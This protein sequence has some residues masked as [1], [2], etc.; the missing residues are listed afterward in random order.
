MNLLF[1]DG[2]VKAMKPTQTVSGKLAW[3][4]NMP[5]ADPA[6]CPNY[7]TGNGGNGSASS[8]NCTDLINGMNLLEQAFK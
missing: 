2:H 6:Q 5:N 1:F 8:Q 3:V 4:P 7:A